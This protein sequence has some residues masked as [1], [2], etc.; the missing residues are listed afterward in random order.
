M[1]TPAHTALRTVASATNMSTEAR[2]HP[3]V[4]R[5]P[6]DPGAARGGMD[7]LSGG[8]NGGSNSNGGGGGGANNVVPSRSLFDGQPAN[9]GFAG[10]P[11]REP[12]VPLR[13]TEQRPGISWDAR[14]RVFRLRGKDS[15]YV[16]RVDDSKNLE[17]LYWGPPLLV[18]DDL[19]YLSKTNV[20]APFD[21]K[22]V[23]SVARKMG[24]DELG[25]IADEHDLS[26]RWKV[27]T[28]AKDTA[29]E[30]DSRP[31]R[32]ENA[33]W[34]LWS[35]ERHRGGDLNKDLSDNVLAMALGEPVEGDVAAA[36][37]TGTV[38][39]DALVADG[40]EAISSAGAADGSLIESAPQTVPS[41]GGPPSEADE[42]VAPA[43][44]RSATVG[45]PAADTTSG[46]PSP[47]FSPRM[48]PRSAAVFPARIGQT[49]TFGPTSP[50]ALGGTTAGLSSLTAAHAG[51]S[52]GLMSLGGGSSMDLAPHLSSYE[53]TNWS[54]LDPELVGKNTKLLEFADHG[55]G[56][57]REPS[58]KVRYKDGSTVSPLEYKSHRIVRGKPSLDKFAPGVYVESPSEATTLIVEMV[59][60]VTNLVVLVHYTVMH[61][62]DAIIRRNVVVNSSSDLVTLLHVAS[63]TLDYDADQYYMTQL[64]GGWARERQVVVRKLDDGLTV[65][66]SSRGASSHQFNPFIV[67]SPG[68]PPA[69]D[70]GIV[71]SYTLVY[72][73]N[74]MASA[75]ISESR[76]LRVSMGLNP[77]GFTWSLSPGEKFSSPEVIMSYSDEGMGK[78]SR[79]LHRLMRQRLVPPRWRN[80]SCPVLLN[81]WYVLRCVRATVGCYFSRV[82]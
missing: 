55:T 15:L 33:S 69:E 11:N 66:K 50:A 61:E 26:E 24:L 77:E 10:G 78:L 37:P 38:G 2:P 23:V 68:G 6:E 64:S 71:T 60:P 73:G 54:K 47:P 74:F 59:D 53:A 81:T 48:G 12:A 19:T 21:P 25:E 5:S 67:I 56:D 18:E 75:E 7:Y 40:E 27:Y 31:R 57:Y 9:G 14:K 52:M 36:T 51:S 49:P 17:H 43:L 34:R 8:R 13:M 4:G 20:P 70:S 65:V 41:T 3:S 44:P 39:T 79:G 28:R 62:Y 16:F 35:M 63:V 22:G 46:R 29:T 76:R 1:S 82:R 45:T 72:S 32:L 42:P 30:N 58:L 80:Y